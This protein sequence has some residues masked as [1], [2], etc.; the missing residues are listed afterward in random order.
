MISLQLRSLF[1]FAEQRFDSNSCVTSILNKKKNKT[2]T[3]SESPGTCEFYIVSIPYVA[4]SVLSVLKLKIVDV[5]N[6]ERFCYKNEPA[7]RV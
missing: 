4:Y 7:I 5:S 6:W 2:R 1:S 3:D